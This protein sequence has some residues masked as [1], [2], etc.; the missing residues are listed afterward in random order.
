MTRFLILSLTLV[1]LDYNS[2]EW[3]LPIVWAV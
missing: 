2:S 3:I 1:K